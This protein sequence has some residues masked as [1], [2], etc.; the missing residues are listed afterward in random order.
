MQELLVT[1]LHFFLLCLG[2]PQWLSDKESAVP[3]MQFQS[4]GQEDPLE[5]DLQPA[6]VFLPG[7][8]HEQRSLAGYSSCG[9]RELDVTEQLSTHFISVLGLSLFISTVSAWWKHF[10]KLSYHASFPHKLAVAG[11]MS[12]AITPW[13][14]E[15]LQIWTLPADQMVNLYWNTTGMVYSKCR[16]WPHGMLLLGSIFL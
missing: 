8:C 15:M 6:P 13:E 5:D 3:K 7:Q 11:D 2:L 10:I 14:A 4:L 9:C 1:W 12:Q 16:S